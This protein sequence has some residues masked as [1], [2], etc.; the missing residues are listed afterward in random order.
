MNVTDTKPVSETRVSVVV[1]HFERQDQLDRLLAGLDMQTFPSARFEVVV[2]DDGSREE[3]RVG[4]RDYAAS[5]VRQ[6]DEGFRPAAARNLGARAA[7][8]D[9]LVFV[10]Q[11]CV[12]APDYL[13][14]VASV[15]TSAWDLTVGH[16]LHADLDG[17]TPEAVRE[18]L[19]G[20]GPAP[21]LIDEPAWLL[22]GYER[23]ADLTRP[24]DR[25]YQL[26][27]GA[28]VSVSRDLH[29]ELGGFDESIRV[30]GGEDWDYGH[31]AHVAGAE[32]RWLADA[33]VWHDGPDLPGRGDL[34]AV[35]N[36]ETVALA[37]RLPDADVRG[38]HLVWSIPE[39]VVRVD[40]A[41][42]DDAVVIASLESLLAGTDAH[43]WLGDGVAS[44]IEDPRVHT[45]EPGPEVL[46]RARWLVDCDAVLLH[47]T[48]LRDLTR[49]APVRTPHLQ[50][51]ST[52][53][54]NRHRLGVEPLRP[55]GLPV[56]VRIERLVET[57]VLERHWQS[58]SPR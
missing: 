40:V 3:P 39:V 23:T 47:G 28:A 42:A 58:R 54:A 50:I 37:R 16:R 55:R 2:A 13:A 1:P 35:K 11:D 10:D 14:K 24:D 22:D 49:S 26:V 31:R 27:L 18:W 15:T 4:R 32:M 38:T 56:G 6:P 33:V 21:T 36:A 44:P 51:C 45:G 9:V 5:V 8:G 41:R 30:Y 43:A 12:P 57:P 29:E 17:W 7:G 52:R 25:A 46:A 53:D 19:G 34:T 48:T 20:D